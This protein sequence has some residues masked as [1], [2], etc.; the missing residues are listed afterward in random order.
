M[1]TSKII[2][3]VLAL[4]LLLGVGVY[5]VDVP[6][7]LQGKLMLKIVSM[8]RNV[9]RFGDPIKIGV[10]SDEFIK[11]LNDLK[12]S[13]MKV[14][15]KDFVAEKISSPADAGKYKLVYVGKEWAANFN[16][17]SNAAAGRQC[18]VFCGVEEGVVNSGCAVSFK[19]M[20]AAPKIV[21]NLENA[22][23]QGTDFPADFLKVTVIV[24]GL[25]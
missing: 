8:D 6:Y 23:K 25:N 7:D 10:S 22:K 20:G 3:A 13:G 21:V 5:A 12:G 14:G 24:G 15:G 2:F 16:A 19:V 9:A 17:V 18:L 1:K 11:A 4:S